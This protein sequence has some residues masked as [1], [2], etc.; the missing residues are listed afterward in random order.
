[1]TVIII[2]CCYACESDMVL[3]NEIDWNH[4]TRKAI[5]TGI[6]MSFISCIMMALKLTAEEK[7]F[8]LDLDT[9]NS[10]ALRYV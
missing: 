1:M 5:T 8:A 9:I 6:L 7:A 2:G 4:N 10:E 3:D